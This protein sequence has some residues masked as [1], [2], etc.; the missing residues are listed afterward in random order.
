MSL[1]QELCLP[2]DDGGLNIVVSHE[3]EARRDG[4]AQR[5]QSRQRRLLLHY[6]RNRR[7]VLGS[8]LSAATARNRRKRMFISKVHICGK[9]TSG[10][11]HEYYTGDTR[12]LSTPSR[13]GAYRYSAHPCSFIQ[14]CRRLVSVTVDLSRSGRARL[15]VMSLILKERG[16]FGRLHLSRI[17][18]GIDTTLWLPPQSRSI[19][20]KR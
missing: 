13:G 19:E 17:G 7:N 18:T 20:L 12:I 2:T 11:T 14:S 3:A 16:L 15:L 10:S 4:Y 1:A 5:V 9:S 6:L 8:V